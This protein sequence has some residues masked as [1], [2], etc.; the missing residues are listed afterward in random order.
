MSTEAA[1]YTVRAC[2]GSRGVSDHHCRTH[3]YAPREWGGQHVGRSYSGSLGMMECRQ[4]R[5][6]GKARCAITS[7]PV[8]V[9]HPNGIR[10]P[11]RHGTKAKDGEGLRSSFFGKPQPGSTH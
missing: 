8:G 10:W 11:A 2:G 9:D 5:G 3:L 4:N 1:L 6:E 7:K